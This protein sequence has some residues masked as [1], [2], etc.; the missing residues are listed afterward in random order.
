MSK[1]IL[2]K[3][4]VKYTCEATKRTWYVV[5]EPRRGEFRFWHLFTRSQFDHVWAYTALAHSTLIV[6]LNPSEC[7]VEEWPLKAEEVAQFLPKDI[8]AILKF[9][10]KYSAIKHFVPRGGVNCV[11][12]VKALLG[13]RGFALTPKGLY[14]QLVTMGAKHG[15]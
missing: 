1:L 10:S 15:R 12:M 7:L 8:T 3:G 14:K 11:V 4:A 13:L 9:E 5:F 6:V 2:S